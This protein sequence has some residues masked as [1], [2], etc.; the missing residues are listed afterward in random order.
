MRGTTLRPSSLRTVVSLLLSFVL[1]A[2]TLPLTA[3]AANADGVDAELSIE[4][5]VTGH[6]GEVPTISPGGSFSYTVNV[7]CSAEKCQNATVSATLPAPLA[8]D[9]DSAITVSPAI[10]DTSIPSAR[11]PA[12]LAAPA[13]TASAIRRVWP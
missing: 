5:Y 13:T 4:A 8:Y 10:A 6:Q 2:I 3:P 9:A 11:V 12:T 7:Q 1:A